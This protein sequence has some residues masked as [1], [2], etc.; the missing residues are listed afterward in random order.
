ML[1]MSEQLLM[2]ISGKSSLHPL[3][4]E[5][6]LSNIQ[7]FMG[8]SENLHSQTDLEAQNLFVFNH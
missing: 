5:F 8:N 1:L 7:Y 4:S 6:E 3:K 2:I